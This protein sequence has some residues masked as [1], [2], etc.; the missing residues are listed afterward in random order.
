MKIV[1]SN[2]IY[3]KTEDEEL[4][5]YLQKQ[6]TYEI[7]E[8]T[9]GNKNPRYHSMFGVVGKGVYWIPNTRLDLIDTFYRGEMDFEISD[10]RVEVFDKIPKPAFTPREDQAEIIDAYEEDSIINGAPG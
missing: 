5:A 9:G 10:K 3:F 1:R 6:L 4:I 2:K 8:Q 7:I